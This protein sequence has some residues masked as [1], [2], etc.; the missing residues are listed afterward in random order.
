MKQ[1]R[2]AVRLSIF[3]GDGDMWHHKPLHH[4]IVRRARTAGLAGAT[5]VRGIEGYGTHSL[6][7]TT[8]LLDLAED[9]PLIVIIVDT[10]E[11]VRSFLPE[12]DEVVT[13]GTVVVDEVQ[14]IRY[15]T[16]PES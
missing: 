7:H 5:V 2:S 14:A 15:T 8:R 12:L 4:E 6:V 13:E 9:L 11:R 1:T 10:A 16:E 3:I